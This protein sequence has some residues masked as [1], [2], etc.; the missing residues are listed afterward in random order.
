MSVSAQKA[1]APITSVIV[2]PINESVTFTADNTIIFRIGPSDLLYWLVQDS[3]F[4]F[5]VEWTKAD[6]I[7]LN[8]MMVIR[9]SG[10]FFD[11]VQI[12]HAGNQVYYSQY[13]IAQQMLD[14]VKSGSDYLDSNF[15]EWT[16]HRTL[17]KL[18][19]NQ[20]TTTSPLVFGPND[21][22]DNAGVADTTTTK[23]GVI[24]RVG[25]ILKC[26]SQCTNFPLKYL[27][28]QLEIRLQLAKVENF[29]CLV[30][31]DRTN[32]S[33]AGD[34]ATRNG[35][36]NNYANGDNAVYGG[37]GAG[38]GAAD[39]TRTGEFYHNNFY[40][41][42]GNGVRPAG[43]NDPLL[44]A[45]KG[46]RATNELAA[47]GHNLGLNYTIKN[48]RLYMFG[49]DVDPGY[50]M[51]MSAENAGGQGKIWKYQMPRINLRNEAT[52]AVNYYISNFQC[53]TE[54]TDKL[55]LWAVRGTNLACM[56]KPH[57]KNMN[58]RFGPYQI[59]KSP[60]QEEN[61]AKPAIYKALVDDTLEYST[62]YYTSANDDLMRCYSIKR[63]NPTAVDRGNGAVANTAD[64][65]TNVDSNSASA[66]YTPPHDTYIMLAGSFTTDDGKPGS[67]S[68]A[69]NS[70]YN[71]HYNI[72]TEE[73]AFTWVLLVDTDYVLTLRNGMLSSTNI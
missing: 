13:N 30:S 28:Q 5:D 41:W 50:D 57:V 18:Y 20:F 16:T 10:M 68:K 53:I 7:A 66:T 42:N 51:V 9:G 31:N 43:A 64:T 59:P 26:F 69:W 67:N 48:M 44:D 12:L 19:N 2:S 22:V 8:N 6:D 24:V 21:F 29:V 3:Y 55:F 33:S 32:I 73:Q 40:D 39:D 60:T 1:K 49:E 58:L 61:W 17:E 15:C 23:R 35:R 11:N 37:I 38:A 63:R 54:N 46:A 70:Q 72:E 14:M 65:H 36:I 47:A 45:N 56:I 62:A 4:M 27:T 25:Q 52:K 34:A 71:L